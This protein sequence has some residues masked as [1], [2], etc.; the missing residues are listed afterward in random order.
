M[1]TQSHQIEDKKLAKKV[2]WAS[3]GTRHIRE[4]GIEINKNKT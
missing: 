2:H 3:Y 4:K 1:F